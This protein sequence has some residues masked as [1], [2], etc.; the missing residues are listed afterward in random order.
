MT[1]PVIPSRLSDLFGLQ[2]PIILAPMAY[3]AG[4]ALVSAC[5][6]A[7][8]LGLV[9]GGY[10]ELDW[11]R[12]E[13]ALATAAGPRERIGCGFI[14]WKLADDA[15]A[16][17]W[18]L[19]HRPAAVMLSF[20]DPAPYAQ[21]IRA[22]KVPLI[23]QVQRLEQVPMC[24]EA[25]ARV[26]VAQ[27][28][29]AG[30]HGMN[31]LHGRAS[32]AFVPELSDWLRQHAPDTVLVAAGGIAD[33]RT[34]LAARVLG[35]DGVLM[36]S[37]FWATQECLAPA[38]AKDVAVQASGDSTAR[39]PV[40][41]I[42]RQKDWPA[43]YDFRVIRNDLHRAWEDRIG[44]LRRAPERVRAD[45]EAG[46]RALDYARANVTVGE[47]VGLIADYPPAEQLIARLK[48]DYEAQLQRLGTLAP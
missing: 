30:G 36:G 7:G 17:D 46:V 31:T 41:D 43:P 34:M 27:G 28:S 18:V 8:A 26:I 45:F 16:L 42:L 3:V 21:R 19:E 39:S 20:G 32:M 38:A 48:D 6:R 15:S 24:L 47:A 11:L 12:R 13:F 5:A 4:G 40:F 14:T 2:V 10:G 29:E 23:C 9:G 25:G 35:A 44:D 22:A 1:Q 37:R 33:G